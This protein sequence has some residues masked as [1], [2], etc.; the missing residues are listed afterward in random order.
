MSDT[1]R[2]QVIGSEGGGLLERRKARRFSVEWPTRIKGIDPAGSS[3]DEGGELA[4]L[5][6][7][8]ALVFVSHAL[9]VGSG[10]EVSIK[11]P[12]KKGSWMEYLGDVVRVE[13]LKPRFGVAMRF[14]SLRPKFVSE[15]TFD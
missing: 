9:R 12:S 15:C 1:A 8:G 10:V 7:S 11:V 13:E 6:S 4:N 3:F 2:R 5:S 14:R